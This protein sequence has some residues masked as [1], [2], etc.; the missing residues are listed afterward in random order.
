MNQVQ[1]DEIRRL[2]SDGFGYAKIAAALGINENTV[3]SFCRR[4]G[5]G[6]RMANTQNDVNVGRGYCKQCGRLIA[7]TPKCK[8]RIF[9]SDGCRAA[10]WNAHPDN[11]RRKAFYHFTCANCGSEFTAYG[12]KKR[13]YCSHACYI[14]GRFGKE[15]II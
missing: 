12:N 1:K 8:R 6:G 7:Q 13:K 11:V 14:S 4:N 3:K 10:W 2:R 9:C 15:V 5:L